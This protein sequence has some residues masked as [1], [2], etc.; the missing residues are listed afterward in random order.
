M[1]TRKMNSH[2]HIELSDPR[3][4]ERIFKVLSVDTR[5]RIVQ[6]LKYK[7]LCVNALAARL[8]IT[9]AAVSQHLRILRD[10]HIIIP[11]KRGYFVHYS[12]NKETL[13]EWSEMVGELLQV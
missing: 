4:L 8:N 12:L 6:L 2:T 1:A 5:L 10:S 9:P 3:K 7:A 13:A 11:E